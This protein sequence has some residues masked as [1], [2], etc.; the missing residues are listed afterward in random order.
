MPS[1]DEHYLL[2]EWM[3]SLYMAKEAAYLHLVGCRISITISSTTLHIIV[4]NNKYRIYRSHLLWQTLVIVITNLLGYHLKFPATF[5]NSL[6]Y[7]S[8]KPWYTS[9]FPFVNNRRLL[10][11]Q[12]HWACEEKHYVP[13]GAEYCL[14]F[15]AWKSITEVLFMFDMSHSYGNYE[16]M[17]PSL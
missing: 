15:T 3:V 7:Y 9:I 4:H 12:F 16:N 17:F 10:I 5:K 6:N 1:L 13:S 14:L 11:K 2:M 8:I